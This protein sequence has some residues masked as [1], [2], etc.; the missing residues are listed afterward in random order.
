MSGKLYRTIPILF[1]E[2]KQEHKSILKLHFVNL[3][4]L[5]LDLV[6]DFANVE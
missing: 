3:L 2:F 4:S 6:N 1:K 5:S